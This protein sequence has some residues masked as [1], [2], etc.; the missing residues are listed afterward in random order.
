MDNAKIR[1]YPAY[2]IAPLYLTGNVACICHA[3]NCFIIISVSTNL[4]H[5]EVNVRRDG[6][7]LYIQVSQPSAKS[8]EL[9]IHCNKEQSS[10]ERAMISRDDTTKNT[11]DISGKQ[12]T[13]E[14]FMKV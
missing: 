2:E 5:G 1:N 7:D 12:Y 3:F 6:S 14:G 11:I 4:L 10:G 9:H 13:R 8:L